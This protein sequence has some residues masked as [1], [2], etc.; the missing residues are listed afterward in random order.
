MSRFFAERYQQME[1]YVPGEQP[2]DMEYI[3]LNTNESPFPPAPSVVEAVTS[4]QIEMLRLYP[5]PTCG[6]LRAKLASLYGYDPE[7][8]FVTNGSDDALNFIFMAYGSKGAIFPDITY[9]FYKVFAELNGVPYREIPL[10]EDFTIDPAEYMGQDQ[11]IL[12]ANPNAPTGMSMDMGAIEDIIRSNSNSIVAIDEAYVD[13]GGQ[14][15]ASLVSKY[16]NLLVVRTYSK[17]R[18]MAGGR[19][20]YAM[21]NVQLIRDLEKLKYS[22]NPYCINRL[23]MLLAE[24]TVDADRYYQDCCKEV[25][26]T[27]AW[28]AQALTELGFQVL[29]SDA[30]FLFAKAPDI[31][32]G[33]LYIALKARGILVRHFG[34]PRIADYVRITVG[35]AQQ[36]ERFIEIVKEIVGGGS[37]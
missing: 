31:G 1:A 37:L 32:G 15:C 25:A 11:L 33:E 34:N 14:S 7:N 8:I 9:G 23:T 19:L 20:G 4:E 12:I 6:G 36:M 13:F 28:T 30:N 26:R 5:D 27:R 17:S 16:D 3:K 22:T 29:P 35:T 21:G 10:R 2:K 18:N 24:A